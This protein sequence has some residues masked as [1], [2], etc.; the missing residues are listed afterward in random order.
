MR[1]PTSLDVFYHEGHEGHEGGRWR[2]RHP[3]AVAC[4]PASQADTCEGTSPETSRIDP[5]AV[6]F[7][8][9]ALTRGRLRQPATALRD[10]RALRGSH[11]WEPRHAAH[12]RKYL[13]LSRCAP[14]KVGLV[15][16]AG[17]EWPLF[18]RSNID[19]HQVRHP[20]VN[21]SD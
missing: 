18:E 11:S 2:P 15:R 7:R 17:G 16:D 1:V 9:R 8:S 19:Q 5:A 3:Q 4:R 13:R 21:P 12:W 6:C 10:L 14:E 20:D